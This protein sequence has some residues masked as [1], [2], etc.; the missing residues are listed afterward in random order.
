[1]SSSSGFS[2]SV[3][4]PWERLPA[5]PKTKSG[6]VTNRPIRLLGSSESYST[7]TLAFSNPYAP[8]MTE[9][10]TLPKLTDERVAELARCKGDVCHWISEH[11]PPYAPRRPEGDR[12]VP[13]K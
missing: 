3:S 4:L 5:T 13:F 9:T 1:M 7:K 2:A 10:A 6:F 12:H 11:V 8:E